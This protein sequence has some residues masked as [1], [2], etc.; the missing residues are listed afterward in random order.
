MLIFNTDENDQLVTH[1]LDRAVDSTTTMLDVDGVGGPDF[2]LKFVH[3][4]YSSSSYDQLH[5]TAK[6]TIDGTNGAKVFLR[7]AGVDASEGLLEF[8]NGGKVGSEPGQNV[9]GSNYALNGDERLIHSANY[10]V[11]LN[12]YSSYTNFVSSTGS[13]NG[14]APGGG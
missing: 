13:T 2:K 3:S 12:S 7:S 11:L 4:S 9:S 14:N 8:A 1:K 6:I 10:G 5:E